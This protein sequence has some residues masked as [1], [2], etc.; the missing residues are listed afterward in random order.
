MNFLMRQ[1]YESVANKYPTKMKEDGGGR[2]VVDASQY[3]LLG[4]FPGVRW[5]AE[6][7]IGRSLAVNRLLK[8]ELLHD[9]TGPKIPILPDNLDELRICFLACAICV[10]KDRQR[11][12]DTNGVR[13]LDE[14]TASE[15]SGNQ[16]LG[17]RNVRMQ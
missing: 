13:E 9:D 1:L 4:L 17:W 11:L 16:G 6:V 7:T 12:G 10:H 8:V 15:A 3:K 14:H 5:V 2:G